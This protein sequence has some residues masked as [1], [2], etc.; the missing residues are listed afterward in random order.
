MADA[1]SGKPVWTG[2]PWGGG[3]LALA[4]IGAQVWNERWQQQLISSHLLSS[5]QASLGVLSGSIMFSDPK[6]GQSLQGR[7]G[8][9]QTEQLI[10][11]FF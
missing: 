4:Y 9:F 2:G 5:G 8:A 11:G 1:E 3:V 7:F 6:T 10:Q